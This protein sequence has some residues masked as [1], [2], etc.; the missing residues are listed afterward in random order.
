MKYF[1]L[2]FS[3]MSFAQQFHK[4]D[5]KSVKGNIAIDPVKKEVSGDVEYLFFLKSET[6]TIKIDAQNMRITNVLINGKKVDFTNTGKTINFFTGYKL[7]INKLVFTYLVKP[8]QTMY[9]NSDFACG[10]CK[11]QQIWT[12]GQGKYTSHWFPS[13][14]DVNEKMVFDLTITFDKRY[15]VNANGKLKNVTT[16]GNNKVWKY[17]MKKPMSSYLLMLAI[18]NYD[19]QKLKSKSCIPLELYYQP[20]D[21]SRV[22]Y[23]YKHSKKIFD[24]L[25]KEIAVKYPWKVY[26]QIPVEDFL[27]AGM[28]NTTSTVFAQ[29][30][31]IDEI[32]FNDR[33]YINVNAHEL[34]HQWFGNLVTATSGKHHWLQEGFATYY[35]LLAEKE[36]FGDDYFYYQLYKT[37]SQLQAASKKD[38]IPLMNEKASTLSFY[39]KGAWALHIIRE[40]IGEKQF[41]KAVKN[42]LKKYAYKNVTT[43]DFLDEIKKVSNFD[44]DKFT[45]VWLEDYR[46]NIHETNELLKKNKFINTLIEI[47]GKRRTAFHEKKGYFTELMKSEVFYPVKREILLQIKSVPF[48]EKKEIIKLAVESNDIKIRQSV[49]ESISLIPEEFKMTYE[50]FLDD[51]SYDTK[52]IAFEN[53]WKNF[54]ED[55]K[56][57]LD[58]A[59]GWIGMNDKALR[60]MYLSFYNITAG[61]DDDQKKELYNELVDYTSMNYES[62]VRQNAFVSVL[63]INSKDERVLKNLVNAT[64]HHKWQF[65]KFAREKIRELIKLDDNKIL[66]D[67]LLPVLTETERVQL[68]RFLNEK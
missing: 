11:N 9:F 36:V 60:I 61:I 31:V 46:F 1:L 3:I 30:Y 39:Q 55:R 7:G 17:D 64:T 67:G 27:Y 20:D 45:K 54:P 32:G 22:P 23:T 29:D 51:D 58:K 15:Y 49:A 53:L 68:N 41:Q 25:E 66:F 38:T 63:E 18:G 13:F 33:N 6:D 44:T 40:N 47:Q 62:S 4:V 2:F 43:A 42:Y 28:E 65:S 37:S 48:D 10:A 26:R 50:S 5:F 8:K 12:Q 57:F 59:S 21:K 19:K 56:L 16:V 52:E 34:A 14:D 35:A 24:F